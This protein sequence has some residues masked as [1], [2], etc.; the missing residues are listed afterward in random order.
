MLIETETGLMVFDREGTIN[1]LIA[2]DGE[3]CMYEGCTLPFDPDPNGKHSISIDHIYPQVKCNAEGWTYEQIW[4]ETNLQLMGRSCNARKGDLVY[5]EEGKLPFRSFRDRTVKLPRPDNC[6]TCY[7][8]RILFFGEE[9]PDC[10]SGP[11]PRSAPKYAQKTPKECSHGWT[12][13]ADHCWMCWI[14]HIERAPASRTV[15]G[16]KE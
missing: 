9:C 3:R 2:R 11:Q 13:P 6:D 8:G 5:D 12:N 7:N 10:G 16:V 15:F 14:G 4:D 1:N